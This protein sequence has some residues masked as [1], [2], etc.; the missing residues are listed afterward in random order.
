MAKVSVVSRNK[1]R[2]VLVARY[3][4]KRRELKKK[5]YN[6]DAGFEERFSAVLELSRLPRNSSRTRV[7]NRCALTGRPRGVIRKFKI[8]RSALR[9]L[10]AEGQVPGVVKSSW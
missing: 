3:K 8:A 10:V 2:G 1:K 4:E 9:R 6:K 7:R 5:I